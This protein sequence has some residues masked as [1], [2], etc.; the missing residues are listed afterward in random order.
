MSGN[1]YETYTISGGDTLPSIAARYLGSQS[2]WREIAALNKLRHPFISD[3]PSDW[4]GPPL[5][6]GILSG[7]LDI[8]DTEVVIPG[9]NALLLTHDAILF[10][11]GQ[12]D[13]GHYFYDA[14]VIDSYDPTTGT[15]AL[16]DAL[17]VGWSTGG[18]YSVRQPPA[19]LDAI[20]AHSGQVIALPILAIGQRSIVIGEGELIDLYGTDIALGTDGLLT[21]VGGD[22]K[23]I[24][25]YQNAQQ[26]L[27]M[28]ATL[29]KGESVWHPQEGNNAYLLIGGP[30]SRANIDAA[31]LY[32]R[33]AL[34][35]DPRVAEIPNV[36]GQPDGPDA[37]RIDADV[38]LINR[39]KQ[40]RVNAVLKEKQ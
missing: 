15:V 34:A 5:T 40:V 7:D 36:S 6:V 37:V 35:L 3:Q 31:A 19:D 12:D 29:P 11:E 33:A 17:T 39:N 10:L 30:L 16:L 25:G 18:R 38:I 23:P 8:G 13:D 22:L 4:F 32:T 24:A 9:E 28:R 2:R 21:L 26:G 20:V 27:W 14:P 1:A